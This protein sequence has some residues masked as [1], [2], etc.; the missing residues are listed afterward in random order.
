MSK[1]LTN[2]T[3]GKDF[4]HRCTYQKKLEVIVSSAAVLVL[5]NT[6]IAFRLRAEF[7]FSSLVSPLLNTYSFIV[8]HSK[9]QQRGISVE[10][11]GNKTQ[12]IL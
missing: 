9:C 7:Q 2:Y 8:N 11:H 6:N 10:V 5:L 3:A 4:T 12:S 1:S